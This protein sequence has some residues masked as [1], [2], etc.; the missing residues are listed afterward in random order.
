MQH[1]VDC[2]V[3]AGGFEH[4]DPNDYCK[5]DTKILKTLSYQGIFDAF[6]NTINGSVSR[7][8]AD[9]TQTVSTGVEK[10]VL[11]ETPE[12]KFLT[13]P[14][15]TYPVLNLQPLQDYMLQSGLHTYQGLVRNTQ[16]LRFES[17]SETIEKLFQNI[18]ISMMSAQALQYV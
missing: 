13:E 4:I 7:G 8:L 17:L 3:L 6:Y 2:S 5:I 9:T 16:P 12:L 11:V 15:E 14:S 1:G 10:T 18:T